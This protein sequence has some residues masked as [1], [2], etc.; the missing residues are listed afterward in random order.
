M[1]I[2]DIV[3]QVQ[4]EKLKA[5]AA[6]RRS[7]V[8]DTA[9]QART[10]ETSLNDR[11]DKLVLVTEAMWEMLSERLGVTVAELAEHVR[12]VDLRDG[13]SDGK[14]GVTAGT[15]LVHCSACQATIP[16]GKANC[17]FCGAAVPGA[18]EDPF[19]I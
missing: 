10:L 12:Q 11:V 3:Q 9:A 16:P 4:I 17:Q 18:T 14:R 19:R 1:S 5:Q 7:E 13:T 2:W 8:A 15:T 6:S